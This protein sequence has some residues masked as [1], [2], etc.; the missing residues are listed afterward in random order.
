MC[1]T[2]PG[3]LPIWLS[4]LLGVLSIIYIFSSLK[5]K[6]NS[7]FDLLPKGK[8][9]MKL[10]SILGSI[11]LFIIISPYSGFVIASMIVLIILLS[12]EYKWYSSLG[13]S[14]AITMVLFLGFKTVLNIP[15]PVNMWGW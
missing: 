8:V 9:L 7:I 3:L 15:L 13:I 10:L 5:E 4:G 6:N 12:P 1:L 14:A 11:F 2:F